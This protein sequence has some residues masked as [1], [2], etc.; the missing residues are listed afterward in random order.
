MRK[1]ACV[2]E[3]KGHAVQIGRKA[4]VSCENTEGGKAYFSHREKKNLLGSTLKKI[5][6]A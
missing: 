3:K 5:N 1:V 6:Q 2:L 4:G